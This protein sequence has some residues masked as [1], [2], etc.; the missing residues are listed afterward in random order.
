M[1]NRSRVFILQG[2]RAVEAALLE[3]LEDAL[4]HLQ[5]RPWG[6]LRP[7]RVIVPSRSLR[8][9]IIGK[10]LQRLQRPIIAIKV[11][12]L[13]GFALEVLEQAGIRPELGWEILKVLIKR[14]AKK[15]TPLRNSLEFFE[16][17]FEVAV[18]SVMDLLDAGL[19]T[20]HGEVLLESLERGFDER[21]FSAEE[22]ARAKAVIN[23]AIRVRSLMDSLGI[24]PPS[25][26]LHQAEEALR[27]H[28]EELAPSSSIFIHGFIDVTAPAGDLIDTLMKLKGAMIFL[29]IPEDPALPGTQDSMALR[30][31]QRFLQRLSQYGVCKLNGDSSAKEDFGWEM[32]RARGVDEE[33]RA[34]AVRIL[35]LMDEGIPP[36]E[37]GVVSRD[38]SAYTTSI[39]IHF[40][41]LAIPFSGLEQMG[42]VHPPGRRILALLDLMEGRR[43]ATCDRWLEAAP[44]RG[45]NGR[46]QWKSISG[47]E[48]RL[49]LRTAGVARLGEIESLD[50]EA[51]LGEGDELVLPVMEVQPEGFEESPSARPMRRTIDGERFREAVGEI[52]RLLS[53]WESWPKRAPLDAHLEKLNEMMRVHL[54][55]PLEDVALEEVMSAGSLMRSQSPPSMELDYEEF[56]DI[57]RSALL[58]RI[59]PPLGGQGGGVQVLDVMEARGRTFSALF[60]LGLNRDV[61]PRP[62]REDPLLPDNVR[63]TLSQVLPD[64][65]IKQRAQLE[66]RHLFAQLL[67]SSSRVCMSWQREDDEGR[68]L[69]PSSLVE[70]LRIH[71]GW[72]EGRDAPSVYFLSPRMDVSQK[73]LLRRPAME[74]AAIAALHLPRREFEKIL[75]VAVEEGFD[76]LDLPSS[77]VPDAGKVARGRVAVLD[78]MDPDWFTPS[79]RERS[80]RLG[81]YLGFVGPP[82]GDSDPRRRDL[83]VTTLE[84]VASCP[85][86]AFV[87]KF[88]GVQRTPDPL[89][90]VPTVSQQLRGNVVHEVLERIVR[91]ALEDHFEELTDAVK[92]GG[93]WVSWPDGE[94]IR[95][96]TKDVIR[97]ATAPFGRASEGIARV[98]T[99]QLRGYLERV[100]EVDW[101]EDHSLRVLG[102]E[103]TGGVRLEGPGGHR[104]IRF[105]ADRA[106]LR[107]G[108][109]CLTDYKTGQHFSE[110]AKK[111]ETVMRHLL[112][113]VK[114]G[115]WLQIVSYVLIPGHGE[116]EGRLL[117]LKPDLSAHLH[118]LSI[119]TGQEQLEE[120]FQEAVSV[121]L[122]AMEEGTLFPR[123]VDPKGKKEPSRCQYCDVS[124]ACLRGDSGM[125]SRL[126]AWTQHG[127]PKGGPQ[128]LEAFWRLWFIGLEGEEEGP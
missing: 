110:T 109:L 28:P 116:V 106:D 34:V 7:V 115:Q 50:L 35:E 11:Q 124:E 120:A 52:R 127:P 21:R 15:E 69:L 45:G 112:K 4:C 49:A 122:G 38:L 87:R 26:V 84:A 23:V 118:I 36:E 46:E 56:S 105:R 30:Y 3:A 86:Q 37:I 119:T 55:W 125:R 101:S 41:R 10:I 53:F 44:E 128:S 99:Q 75:K 60:I 65:S 97:R 102:A 27:V 67:S 111:K 47:Q 73:S 58:P 29:D 17:G 76:L 59:R 78:E 92:G 57:M 117:F 12:T 39:R 95:M 40:H 123:L 16:R 5:R 25:R 70:R 77:V 14:E 8:V 66:E 19:E 93:T 18:S 63:A 24:G 64:I 113:Q 13:H 103:L 72:T 107:D 74:H 126:L 91:E 43:S 100:R 82:L 9:H 6:R 79:G 80:R 81:P 22:L 88:L 114:A 42:P 96:I 32:V 68:P 104:W 2:A 85:W 71:G 83:F 90:A 31:A 89:E 48:L 121:I 94:A 98:L 54:G 61:F 62:L 108:R 1:G 33:V 20:G 51:L